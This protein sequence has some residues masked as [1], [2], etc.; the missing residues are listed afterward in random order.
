[1][2][3]TIDWLRFRTKTS[4]FDVLE[5]MRPM[6][7]TVGEM[8]DLQ[9]G[10]KGQEGW[11]YGAE[12]VIPDH[13]LGR[14]DYGGAS[15]KGW[16]RVNITGKGCEWVQ[17]WSKAEKLADVLV[18]ADIKRIDIAF[19]T[20]NGEVSDDM[21]CNAHDAGKFTTGGRRPVM[22]SILSSNITDGRTRYIGKRENHKYLRCYEKG[23][24]LMKKLPIN[25]QG[26]KLFID[27]FGEVEASKVYRVELELKDVDKYIPW[28]VI[29]RRDDVFAGAYPFCAELLPNAAHWVMSELPSFN[30]KSSL[31]KAL[32]N[33][34]VSYGGALKAAHLAYG[35]DD[36]AALSIIKYVMADEPSN[37]LVDDGVLTVE[38]IAPF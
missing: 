12:I 37:R 5:A 15:Q 7:G 32:F 31:L 13:V 23:W 6:F 17:D 28:T 21:V 29:S 27:Y 24:E 26:D 18:E 36:A 22:Q 20:V 25:K 34:R 2:K 14:I 8:L 38:H 35:G 30:A 33:A 10:V 11:L 16:V 3:T 1:M 19:T 4:H 9:T